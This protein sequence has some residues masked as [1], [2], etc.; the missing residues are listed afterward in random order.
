M[1]H[2]ATVKI[3]LDQRYKKIKGKDATAK[4]LLL[5]KKYP[6]VAVVSFQR[7]TR[8]VKT[9]L[10]FTMQEYGSIFVGASELR[11]NVK[12]KYIKIVQQVEEMIEKGEAIAREL[13]ATF[14]FD[15]FKKQ[16]TT[17]AKKEVNTVKDAFTE[18]VTELE[19][20]NRVGTAVSYGQ[21][22]T[23]FDKFKPGLKLKDLKPA[24]LEQ[25][26]DWNMK[27]GNSITTAGIYL[28][29]LKAVFN[30]ANSTHKLRLD[31]PFEGFSIPAGNKNNNKVTDDNDLSKLKAYSGPLLKAK[32]FWLFEYYGNGMNCADMVLLSYEDVKSP[33][34]LKPAVGDEIHFVRKKTQRTGRSN[35][36]TIIVVINAHIKYVIEN[37]GTRNKSGFLF[38]VL[39]KDMSPKLMKIKKDYFARYVR[40][41]VRTICQELEISDDISNRHARG[42]YITKQVDNF[43]IAVA[44]KNA[45]HSSIAVTQRYWGDPKKEERQKYASIL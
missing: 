19:K 41:N 30:A 9:G 42:T 6:L 21:A 45:G 33:N 18:Y 40:E 7:Q 3:D 10:K 37:Y 15:E 31:Y 1:P 5:A 36:T 16:F 39:T 34:P 4:E 23:S 28:R 38:D 32:D 29:S 24:L 17:P 35:P 27:E 8:Y 20:Q 25:Y 12:E 26:I 43:G 2:F 44:S 13:G 11:K 22:G 14:T